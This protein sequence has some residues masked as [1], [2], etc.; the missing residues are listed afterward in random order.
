M[1]DLFTH[2]AS[3]T[4]GI[5]SV[6]RPRSGLPD[7]TRLE[8]DPEDGDTL[9]SEDPSRLDQVDGIVRDDTS[10]L[11]GRGASRR[12][13]PESA[14]GR[15]DDGT[16]NAVAG[17]PNGF[18]LDPPGPPGASGPV[19]PPP[20]RRPGRPDPEGLAG[21]VGAGEPP[22]GGA[23]R[24]FDA[25]YTRVTRSAPRVDGQDAPAEVAVPGDLGSDLAGAT[26]PPNPGT[27]PATPERQ[28]PRR[29]GHAPQA[30][31][32]GT[33]TRPLTAEGV[34]PRTQERHRDRGGSVVAVAPEA[35]K[36][37]QEAALAPPPAHG[38]PPGSTTSA[39]A[40]SAESAGHAPIASVRAYPTIGQPTATSAGPSVH[41]PIASARV[42]PAI[43]Q[44]TVETASANAS[45]AGFAPPA[46]EARGSLG[47]LDRIREALFVDPAARVPESRTGAT[48]SSEAVRPLPPAAAA[49]PA[50]PRPSPESRPRASQTEAAPTIPPEEPAVR[51]R[52]GR[53]EVKVPPP[54]A[55]IQVSRPPTPQ[56]GVVTL[57]DYL[58]Q[59]NEARA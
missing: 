46:G 11:D 19:H 38:T 58:R 33:Y 49:G 9:S 3:R 21:S 44:P 5:A 23:E 41:A 35:F 57:S 4:L 39:R 56:P 55:A 27:G 22:P 2:L 25:P 14:P 45:T 18:P 53:I 32:D 36:T 7:S 40:A 51:I 37:F 24:R 50:R 59:R 28:T 48:D 31:P 8:A 6:V 43:G 1:T 26:N 52:I 10:G 16:M 54:A 20:V 34:P 30:G 29:G 17:A 15:A 12:P 47:V 42:S 13:G